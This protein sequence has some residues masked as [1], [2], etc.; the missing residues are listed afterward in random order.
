[1]IRKA[2]ALDIQ[3]VGVADSRGSVVD[4]DGLDLTAL[5]A[6]KEKLGMLSKKTRSLDSHSLILETDADVMA[7]AVEY[8]HR[9]EAWD[10]RCDS[11]QGAP[12]SGL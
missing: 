6:T 8:L 10:E 9:S 11:K 2:Y 12:G 3:V 7:G 5:V 1:M 4:P